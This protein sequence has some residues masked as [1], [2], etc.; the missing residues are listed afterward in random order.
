M[1]T[2]RSPSWMYDHCNVSGTGDDASLGQWCGELRVSYKQ[3]QNN[4]P[5]RMKLSNEQIQRLNDAGFEWCLRKGSKSFDERFIDLVAYK[6][7]YIQERRL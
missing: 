3:I 2:Y 6:A 7:K 4:Q 1:S 5:P